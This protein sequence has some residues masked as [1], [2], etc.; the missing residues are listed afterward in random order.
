MRLQKEKQQIMMDNPELALCENGDFKIRPEYIEGY[1]IIDSHCHIFRSVYHLFPSILQRE[2]D[3]HTVA[4]IDKSCFPFSM[5]LFDMNKIYYSGCPVSL[6]SADGIKTRVKL[7]IGALVLNYATVERLLRDM[8]ANGISKAVILQINPPGKSCIE[9]MEEIVTGNPRLCTLASIHPYDTDIPDKIERYMKMHIKGWKL[10][11]HI[12]GVPIDCKETT[13]LLKELSK[14]GL[15]ILSCSG[16]GLPKET[17]AS[18]LLSKKMKQEMKTQRLDKFRSVLDTIPDTVFIMAHSGGYDFEE[19]IRIM[20]EF[21][22]TYTDISLQPAD[23][24]KSLIEEIGSNRMMYGTDYPFVSHAFS[25]LSVL[26][27]TKNEDDRR[28]IFCNTVKRVLWIG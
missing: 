2:R 25:I 8:D 18:S 15:P 6:W 22:N 21:P 4:M 19:M 17:L 13:A 9:D 23:H 7:Y 28:N 14:T 20:K 27:A 12:W 3:D 10:N 1:E 11:P 5:R 24:V 16:T 26:R